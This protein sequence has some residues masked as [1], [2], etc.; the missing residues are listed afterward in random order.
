MTHPD[1]LAA[2]V[3]QR[4]RDLLDEATSRTRATGA[5]W[6]RRNRHADDV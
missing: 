1:V 5:R 2:L 4:Q 6:W 3:R